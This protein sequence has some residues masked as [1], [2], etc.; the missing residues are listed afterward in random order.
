VLLGVKQACNQAFREVMPEGV[1]AVA[2][3][4]A[5]QNSAAGFNC[6]AIYIE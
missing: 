6:S 1:V 2:Q 3:Q 4:H 5:E